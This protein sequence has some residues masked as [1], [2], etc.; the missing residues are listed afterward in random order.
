MQFFYDVQDGCVRLI[1]V[2]HSWD[3]GY[4]LMPVSGDARMKAV[5]ILLARGIRE[6][7]EFIKLYEQHLAMKQASFT[8]RN[9]M[10]E[11][12]IESEKEMEQCIIISRLG[13]SRGECPIKSACKT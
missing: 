11:W 13:G 8:Y 9:I 2:Q 3:R 5:S 4:W 7:T 10:V 6:L 12:D 1:Q